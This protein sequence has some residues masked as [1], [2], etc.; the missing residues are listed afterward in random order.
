MSHDELRAAALALP[1][2]ERARLARDLLRSLD[3]P[4]DQ[5]A[6]AAWITEL[7]RRARELADRSDAAVDWNVVRTR[8]ARRLRKRRRQA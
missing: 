4:A 3:V 7:E 6:D 5:D 2:E 1:P 8:V